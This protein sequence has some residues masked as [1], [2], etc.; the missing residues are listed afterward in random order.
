MSP[1]SVGIY[2]QISPRAWLRGAL[3]GRLCGLCP[4]GVLSITACDFFMLLV[5]GSQTT[6]LVT[7]F[8]SKIGG[9]ITLSPGSSVLLPPHPPG[10]G[11]TQGTTVSRSWWVDGP[12]PPV[13]GGAAL[14]ESHSSPHSPVYFP[15]K[16]QGTWCPRAADALTVAKASA[17]FRISL[18]FWPLGI[19]LLSF[20]PLLIFLL[21]HNSYHRNI[22]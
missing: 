13:T 16:T 2:L 12:R 3:P 17:G 15:P 18:H 10:P 1:F 5:W 14:P 8:C 7:G 20:S 19:S 11:L 4:P 6:T 9:Q 22:I 21:R